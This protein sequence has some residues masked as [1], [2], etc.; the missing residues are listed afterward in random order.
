MDARGVCV[1]NNEFRFPA[2]GSLRAVYARTDVV[3]NPYGG[4]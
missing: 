1:N 4:R 2:L 3:Y